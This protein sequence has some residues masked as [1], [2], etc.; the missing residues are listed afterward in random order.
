MAR[1]PAALGKIGE[2]R[3]TLNLAARFRVGKEGV[4]LNVTQCNRKTKFSLGV[5]TNSF[6][7]SG[8]VVTSALARRKSLRSLIRADGASAACRLQPTCAR[9]I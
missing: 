8:S 1:S 5:S 3:K 2:A 6:R 4:N 9:L 7:K